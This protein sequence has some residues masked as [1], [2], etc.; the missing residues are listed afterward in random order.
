[1]KGLEGSHSPIRKFVK[2][3]NEAGLSRE[4]KRK[5]LDVATKKS[6]TEN[7]IEAGL[8]NKMDEK[9]VEAFTDLVSG[10]E[11]IDYRTIVNI[12]NNLREYGKRSNQEFVLSLEDKKVVSLLIKYIEDWFYSDGIV[13]LI[14]VENDNGN[15]D[16]AGAAFVVNQ[17]AKIKELP[18]NSEFIKNF[19][20][21]KL[22][23][24]V[25]EVSSHLSK[26]FSKDK[27]VSERDLLKA[28]R[29]Q[30]R[31]ELTLNFKKVAQTA[32]PFFD[33]MHKKEEEFSNTIK[34]ASDLIMQNIN[35]FPE[36][37]QYEKKDL[38]ILCGEINKEYSRGK[39]PVHSTVMEKL[40]KEMEY[41]QIRESEKTIEEKFSYYEKYPDGKS[42]PDRFEE[43][44][45]KIQQKITRIKESMKILQK[46]L[47]EEA[48]KNKG[49]GK[50]TVV[51]KFSGFDALKSLD[52]DLI[53]FDHKALLDSFEKITTKTYSGD[54]KQ[55]NDLINKVTD[56]G[57]FDS[58][59][60]MDRD[61]KE[62]FSSNEWVLHRNILNFDKIIS[63]FE[64]SKTALQ[65]SLKNTKGPGA[66]Y[67]IKSFLIAAAEMR[68]L[69]R[70]SK[71]IPGKHIFDP[72]SI[73]LDSI[74]SD[75]V[76]NFGDGE[77]Y[78]FDSNGVLL[79]PD[80]TFDKMH[81]EPKHMVF[82]KFALEYQW[83]KYNES[84][85]TL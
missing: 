85:Q 49:D 40:L 17:L 43:S 19:D 1:M 29:L 34:N 53:K 81:Y 4:E 8:L 69:D 32:Q 70:G 35:I 23:V 20:V 66:L 26:I 78:S 52:T 33:K 31:E 47:Q 11:K 46:F 25:E 15:K 73:Y 56:L 10:N 13:K 58:K 71:S 7:K 76:Y 79:P 75:S 72:T 51:Q 48:E 82:I 28:D 16:L 38:E 50:K 39:D 62:S 61:E 68:K 55:Y 45:K 80:K 77:Q 12:G 36:R 27:I 2:V 74:K 41:N 44:K 65:E 42:I 18:E 37:Y 64:K 84:I 67:L 83:Q 54:I 21:E 24:F 63:D 5:V 6:D 30:K 57:Y 9:M 22:N 14:P 3:S 59:E 60:E